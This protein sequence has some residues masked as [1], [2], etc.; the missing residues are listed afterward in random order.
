MR[1]RWKLKL[2]LVDDDV[3]PTFP[4]TVAVEELQGEVSVTGCHDILMRELGKTENI[5]AFHRL[6]DAAQERLGHG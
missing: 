3:P 4:S 5:E 2:E 1:I 6:G